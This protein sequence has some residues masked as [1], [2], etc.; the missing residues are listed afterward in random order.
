MALFEHAQTLEKVYLAYKNHY[1]FRFFSFVTG[2]F[3]ILETFFASIFFAFFLLF[4]SQAFV[5]LLAFVLCLEDRVFLRFCVAQFPA[6]P[7]SHQSHVIPAFHA[8]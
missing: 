6:V 1:H 7:L 5:V 3:Y 8:Y 2:F 4:F